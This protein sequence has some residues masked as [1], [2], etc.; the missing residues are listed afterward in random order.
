MLRQPASSQVNLRE[1]IFDRDKVKN[2]NEHPFTVPV[3]KNLH[4]IEIKS[5]VCFF[6]G[7]NGTGK[8]TLLEAIA[9]YCGFGLDGGTINVYQRSA[10]E[11]NYRPSETLAKAL[12]LSWSKKI[13]WGYYF[14]AES[15]FNIASLLD[16]QEK[17]NGQ[18]LMSYGDHS[19]HEQSHGESFMSLFNHKF[20]SPG[21]YL[22]DE[23][24]A[25]LSPQKQ[26]AF[27]IILHRL[28]QKPDTQIIIATHSPILLAF[29]GAQIISFDND[30]L[31]EI[32]YTETK[33]YEITSSFL[34]HPDSYL[35]RLFEEN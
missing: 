30:T 28:S 13:L 35:H 12:R 25:A 31:E 16:E 3:I 18:A 33:P 7:E 8:S 4:A 29:P 26:L 22:L 19:L 27:M 23:P 32:S 6:V 34:S 5:R 17:E 24:E 14:R 15:F 20:S 11:K 9:A 2:W 1:I 10:E 21:F